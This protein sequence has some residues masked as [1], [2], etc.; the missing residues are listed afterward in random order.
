MHR[1]MALMVDGNGVLRVDMPTYSMVANSH[2]PVVPLVIHKDGVL[3]GKALQ[4]TRT[5]GVT[6]LVD[7]PG[8]TPLDVSGNVDAAAMRARYKDH[9]RYGSATWT[10]PRVL[11]DK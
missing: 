2:L 1:R 5:H 11:G 6:V 4:A 9:T 10:P 7:L 3:P 8:N